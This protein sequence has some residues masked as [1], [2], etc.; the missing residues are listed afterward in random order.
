MFIEAELSRIVFSELDQV[1]LLFLREKAGR[2][3][4]PIVV[5]SVEAFIINRAVYEPTVP[6][7][8]TH[9]L[10]GSVIETLGGTLADVVISDVD[11]HTFYARLRIRRGEE[12][13]EVDC[14]PSDAIAAAIMHTPRLRILV[15]GRILEKLLRET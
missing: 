6:R 11:E 1:H 15:E 2:R 9:H 10:L 3:E 7:P 4:F 12:V 14:R 5:G 8:L 13:L